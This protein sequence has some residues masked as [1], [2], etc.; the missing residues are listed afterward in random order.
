MIETSFV[1]GPRFVEG[2]FW[3]QHILKFVLCE[4]YY[5]CSLVN[6][7]QIGKCGTVWG[8]IVVSVM[9]LRVGA[10]SGQWASK[11]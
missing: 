2:I 6:M 11:L 7:Y 3:C 1:L 9:A 10:L 4:N 5:N 8:S